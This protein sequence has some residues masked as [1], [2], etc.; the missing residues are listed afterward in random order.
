MP[1]GYFARRSPMNWRENATSPST[2]LAKRPG[3]VIRVLILCMRPNC[4]R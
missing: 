4:R 3:S 2:C 1:I